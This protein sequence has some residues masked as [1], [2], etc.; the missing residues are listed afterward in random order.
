MPPTDR[1]IA[2]CQA[3]LNV[4]RPEAVQ[5]NTAR[6]EIKAAMGYE[7]CLIDGRVP[8]RIPNPRVWYRTS[9]IRC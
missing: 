5:S 7:V 8:V 6:W 4:G 9:S 2:R 1:E 3:L